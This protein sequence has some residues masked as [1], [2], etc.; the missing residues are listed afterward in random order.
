MSDERGG[1]R[2]SKGLQR[3]L[4]VEAAILLIRGERVM[5]KP[6]RIE[7]DGL[8]ECVVHGPL[9]LGMDPE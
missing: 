4:G 6:P 7:L 2:R 5:L 8:R 9:E 3:V 1:G